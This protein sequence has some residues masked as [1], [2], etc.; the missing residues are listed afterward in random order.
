MPSDP[1][2][3]CTVEEAVEEIHQGRMIVLIDDEDREN[4]GDLAL[5]AEK[6]TPDAINFMA[7]YGRGL[8]C[9]ALTE[10]RCDELNLP[11]MSPINTSVHGTAFCEAIDGKLGVTT[12]ISA[13]DRAITILTAIDA[14]TRPQDLARPGHMF[15]LRARNGGV[16]VRAGQTEASVDLARIAGLNP[17]GVICE[18]MN[19]DGTMA[20]V[21]QLIEFCKEHN[22][23]MLTVADL[24]RYRMQHERYVRRIAEAV[25]PTRYGD[26]RMIA[27]SSDV[28]HDQH[29]ALV[30]GELDGATPP[31]VRV[32][33]HCLT[34]DVFGSVA[35]DCSQLVAKSLELIVKENRGVFLYLHHTGRGFTVDTP[36]VP[37]TLPKI[38]FHTRG[39]L[40]REVARQRMVQ[41]ESGTGA[42]I[43]ID[44]GLKD[45]RVV[46]NHPKKVVAL[47]GYGIRIA[48][49]VPLDLT[50]PKTTHQWS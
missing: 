40:D 34:G 14:K 1:N 30:R 26:F 47:E 11:L 2:A 19:E 13:S 35:C 50:M 10:Q 28:D 3:F 37:G 27:Y 33:S 20:R 46:T 48:D 7:K 9:L 16:L 22:V 25:L 4:E 32:H 43:L 17:S 39:Q 38:H 6:I 41:H 23:K 8:I 12:G 29:I 44:L 36:E 5:A 45:I 18:I 49:Q 21:P 31:L 42:Q 24:I 15:P